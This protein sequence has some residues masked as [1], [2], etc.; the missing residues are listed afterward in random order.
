VIDDLIAR[1]QFLHLVAQVR[2]HDGSLL[3]VVFHERNGQ[4]G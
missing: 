2:T 1:A 4:V 3:G